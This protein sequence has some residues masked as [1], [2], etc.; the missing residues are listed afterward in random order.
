[1]HPDKREAMVRETL[2]L[3]E[4]Q[5]RPV[6]REA[7]E[8]MMDTKADQEM[9]QNSRYTVLVFRDEEQEPGCPQMIHL[10]I[11]RNDRTRPR[12]E[13]YRDFQRIKSEIVGPDHEGVE[14][15]PAEHRVADLAD[16]YHIYVIADPEFQFG[17]GFK[18]GMRAG[19]I[20]GSPATQSPFT[21]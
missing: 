8:R 11:R 6:T 1:M 16:Q 20:E 12:E 2:K 9:W 4:D 10:S 13:R 17:F 19:P 15:Y 7:V 3:C 14:L 18:E 5:G 21:D